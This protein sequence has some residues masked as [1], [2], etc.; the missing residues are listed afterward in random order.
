M[1]YEGGMTVLIGLC[2][3][4]TY[5]QLPVFLAS[6]PAISI[7]SGYNETHA[8]TFHERNWPVVQWSQ[9]AQSYLH[10]GFVFNAIRM[11]RHWRRF[12][13]DSPAQLHQF[14]LIDQIMVLDVAAWFVRAYLADHAIEGSIWWAVYLL[15]ALSHLCFVD[16]AR[17]WWTGG[18]SFLPLVVRY[19]YLSHWLHHRHNVRVRD[20][21]Q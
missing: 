21:D 20:D 11:E 19:P 3:I 8:Q 5:L 10:I 2:A 16:L 7:W 15:F 4:L 9:I 6:L 1:R 17:H 14:C 18:K 13:D 12:V